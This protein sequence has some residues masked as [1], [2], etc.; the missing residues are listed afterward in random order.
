MEQQAPNYLS[1]FLFYFDSNLLPFLSKIIFGVPYTTLLYISEYSIFEE[2]PRELYAWNSLATVQSSFFFIVSFNRS[3][4]SARSEPPASK[5]SVKS[6]KV[7]RSKEI[8][9]RSVTWSTRVSS[10]EKVESCRAFARKSCFLRDALMVT[11]SSSIVVEDRSPS[12]WKRSMRGRNEKRV[13]LRVAL[14][15]AIGKILRG[16]TSVQEPIFTSI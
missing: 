8:S 12:A 10:Y 11:G 5:R 6:L 3:L 16:T 7:T 14:D 13:S 15:R 4:L 9:T 2:T 1:W